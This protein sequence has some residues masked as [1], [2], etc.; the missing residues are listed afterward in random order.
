MV[1]FDAPVL[2]SRGSW[3]D[4]AQGGVSVTVIRSPQL[5]SNP[6]LV[7]VAFRQ[8]DT[9]EPECNLILSSSS[10]LRRPSYLSP[11]TASTLLGQYDPLNP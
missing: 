7:I 9:E 11:V 3:D 8:Y 4:A 1:G 2:D 6:L 10:T 5:I